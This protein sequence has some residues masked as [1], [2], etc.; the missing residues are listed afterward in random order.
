MQQLVGC[1]GVLVL[2]VVFG[3]CCVGF[4]VV[5]YC[6]GFQFIDGVMCFVVS[7]VDGCEG[8]LGVFGLVEGGVGY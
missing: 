6:E 4:D 8:G 2:V 3:V 1:V 5:C 7:G